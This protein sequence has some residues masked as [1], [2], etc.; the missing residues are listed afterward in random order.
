MPYSYSML[1]SVDWNGSEAGGV[2]KGI[3]K[4]G[5]LVLLNENG[6]NE[7]IVCGDLSLRFN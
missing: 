2:A 5:H 6:Q 4:Y 7:E 1:A 3:N